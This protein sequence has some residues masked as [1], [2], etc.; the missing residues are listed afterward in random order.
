MLGAN[1][2]LDQVEAGRGGTRLAW[3]K[4]RDRIHV[5]GG[6]PLKERVGVYLQV[7]CICGYNPQQVTPGRRR[8]THSDLGGDTVCLNDLH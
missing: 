8:A 2:R 1:D 6:P 3:G 5:G 7:R 4:G